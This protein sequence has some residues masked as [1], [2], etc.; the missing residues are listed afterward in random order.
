[1][2][3]VCVFLIPPTG[4][5]PAPIEICILIC[6]IKESELSLAVFLSYTIVIPGRTAIAV[7]GI[8]C[9]L[10]SISSTYGFSVSE[11]MLLLH[12]VRTYQG[13]GSHE[14]HS[15]FVTILI[16]FCRH[17]P[18]GRTKGPF[19]ECWERREVLQ[20]SADLL[21]SCYPCASQVPGPGFR[22]RGNMTLKSLSCVHVTHMLEALFWSE[23]ETWIWC[24]YVENKK[25]HVSWL[26]SITT[27]VEFENHVLSPTVYTGGR[28]MNK[29]S[30]LQI[31]KNQN[32][33]FSVG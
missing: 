18:R 20:T 11:V 3:L 6:R 4:K 14:H 21:L 1:M 33:P 10:S 28:K 7:D 26:S 15:Q 32:S 19:P 30:F 29:R 27:L 2:L 9:Q 23:K 25:A 5:L 8:V 12:P 17:C 22:C 13:A 24:F 16:V 31:G